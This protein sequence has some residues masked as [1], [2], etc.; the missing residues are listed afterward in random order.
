MLQN[1]KL[2]FV[3]NSEQNPIKW[4]DT[5]EFKKFLIKF[6]FYF[7]FFSHASGMQKFLDQGWYPCHTSDSSHSSENTDSLTIRL[8]GNSRENNS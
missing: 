6:F 1:L 8:P 3:R 2:V 4:F 7:L 5:F